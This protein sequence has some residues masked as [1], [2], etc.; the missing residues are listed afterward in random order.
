MFRYQ[1]VILIAACLFAFAPRPAH[2]CVIPCECDPCGC[3]HC[4]AHGN[5]IEDPPAQPFLPS[6]FASLNVDLLANLPLSTFSSGTNVLGS[7]IWGWT[8]PLTRREYAIFGLNNRTVFVDISNP[9]TPVY[10]GYLP[11]QTGSSAWREMKTY[12]NHAF[13]VSDGNGAHGM[14]VFNLE[15]LRDVDPASAPVAFTV[16]AHYAGF[17]NAHN[18]AINEESGYAYPMGGNV[19]SGGFRILNIQNPTNPVFAGDV[20]GDGYI[21]DAQVATY[22]GPDVEFRGREIAFCCNE[23]TVTII[24]VTNKA[25]PV[26]LSKVSYPGVRYCHQGIV[27]ED[28]SIFLFND[29]L[30]MFNIPGLNTRS[31]ILDVRSL[32]NPQYRGVYTGPAKTVAHN[33]YIKGKLLYQANYTSGLRVVDVSKIDFGIGTMREVAFFDT[34]PANDSISFNGAWGCYPFFDSGSIIVGDRQNGLFVVRLKNRVRDRSPFKPVTD[35]F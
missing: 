4:L 15:R 27:N 26:I 5:G 24:D 16:D 3:A 21:H 12:K 8:D 33:M 14:Q 34:Y 17:R 1:K 13:I 2:A 32:R 10:L 9:T 20:S 28:Q 25:T 11:T 31:H 22:N 19:A 23:D 18:I 7:D 30:E 35:P 29:E 6:Q